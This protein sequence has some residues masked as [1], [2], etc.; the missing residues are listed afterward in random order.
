[1]CG[2]DELSKP[3]AVGCFAI[4]VQIFLNIAEET[5]LGFIGP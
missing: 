3:V 1:M 2:F 5:Q 4:L